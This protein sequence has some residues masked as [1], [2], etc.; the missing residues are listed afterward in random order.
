MKTIECWTDE[1]PA[2]HTPPAADQHLAWDD[3]RHLEFPPPFRLAVDYVIRAGRLDEEREALY[4]EINRRRPHG[5]LW[6][7]QLAGCML[8]VP[9]QVRLP[10]SSRAASLAAWAAL[11]LLSKPIPPCCMCAGTLPLPLPELAPRLNEAP[12]C[13]HGW[14]ETELWDW[15]GKNHTTLAPKEQYCSTTE[16]YGPK[17]P[18]CAAQLTHFYGADVRLVLGG[19]PGSGSDAA[20]ADVESDANRR[21]RGGSERK[22]Q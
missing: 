9:A 4:K 17:H 12:T 5:K 19:E 14:R 2:E 18:H 8:V 7:L 21:R 1:P 15:Q 16:Y 13:E 6:H 3:F 20:G 22:L 11:P 10:A